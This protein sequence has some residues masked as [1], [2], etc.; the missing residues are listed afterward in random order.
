MSSLG[1]DAE[2]CGT[3]GKPA[4]VMMGNGMTKVASCKEHIKYFQDHGYSVKYAVEES[5]EGERSE[6]E[7]G[8]R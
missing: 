3:C 1:K 2:K 5:V 8:E 6:G 4:V 7:R